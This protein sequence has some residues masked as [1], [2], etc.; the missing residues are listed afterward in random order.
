MRKLLF[1]LVIVSIA[2]SETFTIKKN[3]VIKTNE[4]E[5]YDDSTIMVK[6]KTQTPEY[7]NE[8]E[9]KYNLELQQVLVIGLYIYKT[10]SNII[11]LLHNIVKEDNVVDALPQFR[12]KSL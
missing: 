6:F 3:G 12:T 2:F 11:E 9:K 1:L 4:F 10:N 7:I 5:L 8:F